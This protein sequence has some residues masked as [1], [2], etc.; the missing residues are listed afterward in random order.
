[1]KKIIRRAL[2]GTA[3]V[4]DR[5]P[6]QAG[7]GG[8]RAV[9]LAR[10]RAGRA[11]LKHQLQRALLGPADHIVEGQENPLAQVSTAKLYELHTAHWATIAGAA[12]G[13][14]ATAVR[15]QACRPICS[16]SS[17]KASMLRR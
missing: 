14:S 4:C 9:D 12:I 16:R 15:W 1:M 10:S 7:Q 6:R 3:S 13:S 17:T 8:D 5:D 2:L 11:A